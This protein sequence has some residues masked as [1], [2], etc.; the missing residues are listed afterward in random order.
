MSLDSKLNFH[1][2]KK[3]RLIRSTKRQTFSIKFEHKKAKK[4]ACVES[5]DEE[6]DEAVDHIYVVYGDSNR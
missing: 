2:A 6:N 3:N 4:F 1:V 5:E